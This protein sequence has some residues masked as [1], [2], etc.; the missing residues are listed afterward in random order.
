[1]RGRA[2]R[3]AGMAL[4]MVMAVVAV[5]AS[6]A[7][8]LH[9]TSMADARLARRELERVRARAAALSGYELARALLARDDRPYFW[10]PADGAAPVGP[11]GGARVLSDLE[12]AY[13][14][15]SAGDGE[16]MPMDGA[17][18]MVRIDDEASRINLNRAPGD[19]VARLVAVL[20]S[21][22]PRAPRRALAAT[23]G[24][25]LGEAT[26]PSLAELSALGAC[27]EDWRDGDP[28]A[29]PLGA[30]LPEYLALEPVGYRPRDGALE[31]VAELAW[32]KG[33][34][35]L[36][37]PPAEAGVPGGA[38]DGGPRTTSRARLADLVTVHGLLARVNANQAAP[39]VLAAIPGIYESPL[40]RELLAAI[41]RERPVRDRVALKGLLDAIDPAASA[42]ALAWLDVRSDYFRIAV[43]AE[44]GAGAS[45]RIEAV[46]RRLP[47]G[48]AQVVGWDE[49]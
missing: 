20:A 42:Q 45:F 13:Q 11:D 44:A 21:D 6:V 25:S 22:D 49:G 31:S 8:A 37:E 19:Q 30:E 1:M 2:A 38:G 36:L 41:D 4:L 34:A 26:G 15:L 40:R 12:L 28:V 33:F 5:L 10:F 9:Q 46:V 18:L 43:R 29:R 7:T 47:G 35:A 48:G 24:S 14:R 27:L 32:V 3:R 23:E 17:G 39:E 16:L